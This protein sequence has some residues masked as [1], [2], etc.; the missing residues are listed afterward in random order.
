MK[1]FQVPG[2]RFKVLVLV[3]VQGSG[4][5]IQEF[6]NQNLPEPGTEL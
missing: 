5:A 2:S 3:R 6:A 1:R 4:F